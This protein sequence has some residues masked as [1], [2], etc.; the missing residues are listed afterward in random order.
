[1]SDKNWLLQKYYRWRRFVPARLLYH[2]DHFRILQLSRA[3]PEALESIRQGRLRHVL[4]TAVEHV[5]FY[6]RTVRLSAGELANEPVHELIAHFPY[7]DKATVMACQRDFLDER[8]DPRWL[9]YTTSSG[10]TGEG[11]GV[12]RTKR[13][14]DI[15]KAFYAREWSRYGFS[16]DKS[17]YLRIGVDAARLPHESPT[18]SFGNRLLL[19]PYHLTEAHKPAIVEAINRFKPR[20]IHAY[21]STVAA[22]ADLLSP[23]DLDCGIKA[24][25]LASEPVERHQLAAVERVFHCPASISYGLTERTN[26]A[27]ASYAKGVRGAYRFDPLYAYNENFLAKGSPEIVG[28]SLWNDVMPLIRYRT[29]DYGAIDADCVC[30]VIEGRE[31]E[32]LLDR[33]GNLIAGLSINIDDDTWGFVRNY[34][35][36]HSRP[37]EITIAVVP[38]QKTLTQSEKQRLLGVQQERWGALFDISLEV[39]PDIARAPNGKYRFV[40]NGPQ[41]KTA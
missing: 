30:Q 7:T 32:F 11:I 36:W 21:P 41:Q 5:P 2:A 3:S 10:S 12:W 25:L 39:V 34:Q 33:F 22:L 6:R 29:R 19:S 8:R 14:A 17:R 37:G 4:Q 35:I 26:L 20:F 27:F 23:A 16:F 28:T 18:R 40:I 9:L 15:E 13:L 24:V 31:Q 38:R 1:M